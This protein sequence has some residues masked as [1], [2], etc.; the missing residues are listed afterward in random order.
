MFFDL[1]QSL[2]EDDDADGSDVECE[3]AGLLRV[4]LKASS[5]SSGC[6]DW[7]GPGSFSGGILFKASAMEFWK[8]VAGG[9]GAGAGDE[10][11]NG[12][13]RT[14]REGFQRLSGQLKKKKV[15]KWLL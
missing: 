11:D 3:A 9:S 12:R 7:S 6:H 1:L 8:E 10:D 15:P 2:C 14:L 5:S 13:R 4:M